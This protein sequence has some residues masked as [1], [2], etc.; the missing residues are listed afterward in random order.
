MAAA[1]SATVSVREDPTASA[2][3][4]AWEDLAGGRTADSRRIRR[5]TGSTDAQASAEGAAE[6]PITAE[7]ADL[8]AVLEARASF[9]ET[10]ASLYFKPLTQ[11]QIDAMAVA[12]FSA[13]A[14]VNDA[15]AEG[16]NDM[17]R[18]L[19]RRNSGTRQELAVD[20]TGAFAGTSTYEGKTAVPYKSVFTSDKGL[21]YQEGYQEVFAAFKHEAVRR[22]AGLDWPDDHL[23]FMC[24]FMAI[25]SRR[26]VRAL[27][28]GDARAAA[29]NLEASREFLERHMASWFNDF[30]S[31]ANRLL[32]T[33][34]YRGVLKV[35]EG[36]FEL[37]R[38]T[39][40]D[41][42]DEARG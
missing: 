28:Q 5:G 29:H 26:A 32:S 7:V 2:K 22:R 18:Y 6:A 3:P 15:F 25:L 21:M 10:L 17:A 38:E 8:C 14:D 20:F 24:Q 37:D 31:L 16:L 1:V 34:F 9:Y 33:R 23:S 39:V 12:D 30:A 13:Y 27:E 41:L 19:R 4:C 40:A 35:T 42:L 11:E 36:F